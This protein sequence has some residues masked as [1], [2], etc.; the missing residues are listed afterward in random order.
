[1]IVI[2]KE[3]PESCRRCPCR[4]IEYNASEKHNFA[5]CFVANHLWKD[6]DDIPN[7][8]RIEECPLIDATGKV[9]MEKDAAK[10]LVM[11]SVHLGAL[12][13]AIGQYVDGLSNTIQGLREQRYGLFHKEP[14]DYTAED[15][16]S[17]FQ[18]NTMLGVMEPIVETISKWHEK[19]PI[20][21]EGDADV[22]TET[23]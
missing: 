12:Q 2:D 11:H 1:M 15:T 3:M 8:K 14:K 18:L 13:D 19:D 4:F 16:M 22:S 23:R 6:A 5:T 21:K 20:E 17:L 10:K 9:L 7:G